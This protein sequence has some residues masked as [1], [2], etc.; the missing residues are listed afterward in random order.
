MNELRE[1]IARIF[2][3]FDALTYF[4]MDNYQSRVD[5]I[6]VVI[7]EAGYMKI[8]SDEFI[9]AASDYCRK[10]GWREID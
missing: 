6:L 8:G 10:V 5:Q 9:E 7:K 3:N 1:K 4:S 2:F